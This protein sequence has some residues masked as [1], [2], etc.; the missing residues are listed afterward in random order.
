LPDFY[1]FFARF[2]FDFSKLGLALAIFGFFLQLNLQPARLISSQL[3]VRALQMA[4]FI[5]SLVHQY[6]AK[7]RRQL[8]SSQTI[9]QLADNQ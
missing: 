1:L 3:R 6:G 8:N 4:S 9:K 7:A 2:L 5:G